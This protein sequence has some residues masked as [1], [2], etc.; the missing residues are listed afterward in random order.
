MNTDHTSNDNNSQSQM[1]EHEIQEDMQMSNT[2]SQQEEQ[3]ETEEV[4]LQGMMGF[5]EYEH[6]TVRNLGKLYFTV[7]RKM[8]Y[9]KY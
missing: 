4:L 6:V 9:R 7:Q 3:T 8:M 1:A 2:E 5:D